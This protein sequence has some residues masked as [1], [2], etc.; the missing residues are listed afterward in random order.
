ML[1]VLYGTRTDGNVAQREGEEKAKDATLRL[2]E[3]L[4]SID[5]ILGKITKPSRALQSQCNNVK[6]RLCDLKNAC[7][8]TPHILLYG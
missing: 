1:L 7:I 4:A 5:T 2:R 3:K 6:S 8:I